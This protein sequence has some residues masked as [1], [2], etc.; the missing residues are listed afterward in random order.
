MRFL[1]LVAFSA[2]A[3]AQDIRPL[4][5]VLVAEDSALASDVVGSI[6]LD[7]IHEGDRVALLGFGDKITQRLGFTNSRNEIDRAFV[8]FKSRNQ[9]NSARL[10]DALGEAAK[11]FQGPPDPARRRVILLIYSRPNDSRQQT[12]ETVFDL[13]SRNEIS[14]SVLS[15]AAEFRYKKPKVENPVPT[16]LHPFIK[17]REEQGP[18]NLVQS[19]AQIVAAT[20]GGNVAVADAAVSISVIRSPGRIK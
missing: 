2:F 20:G 15:R 19:L 11:L 9:D 12:R 7:T 5:L 6:R 3:A 14:L 18:E 4:D 8:R 16:M 10:W 17:G 13:L 1:A